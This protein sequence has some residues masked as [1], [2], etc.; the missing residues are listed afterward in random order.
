MQRLRKK[1]MAAQNNVRLAKTELTYR[2]KLLSDEV[3]DR[4]RKT[5]DIDQ[6]IK[7]AK[8]EIALLVSQN[9]EI[10]GMHY[11][12]SS[13][14]YKICPGVEIDEFI[15]YVNLSSR[16]DLNCQMKL[17]LADSLEAVQ[18]TLESTIASV[19]S[20]TSQNFKLHN[21][22]LTKLQ[23][24]ANRVEGKPS[25]GGKI[26]GGAMI[27]LGVTLTVAAIAALIAS[28]ATL[29]LTYGLSTGAGYGSWLLIMGGV[30][31]I[32][33]GYYQYSS[34]SEKKGL[35]K[36]LSLFASSASEVVTQANPNPSSTAR[37]K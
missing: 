13:Y 21:E 2:Q 9:K 33:A 25:L 16:Q 15:E 32:A 29:T 34:A 30:A 28:I 18:D 20:P 6:R 17:D 31:T 7:H 37:C 3:Q 23:N 27:A 5:R 14:N 22:K 8:N 11:V 10:L 12:I 19:N 1:V 26:L 4:E 36:H 35:S 24:V